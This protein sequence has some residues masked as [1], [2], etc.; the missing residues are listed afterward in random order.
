MQNRD[1][2]VRKKLKALQL[3]ALVSN[4][5]LAAEARVRP[6]PH[7]PTGNMQDPSWYTA[8]MVASQLWQQATYLTSLV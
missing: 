4:V 1:C 5:C 3:P 7:L 6:Y 8:L 2:K